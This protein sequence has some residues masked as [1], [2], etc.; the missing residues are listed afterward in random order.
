MSRLIIMCR[1]AHRDGSGHLDSDGVKQSH[2]LGRRLAGLMRDKNTECACIVTSSLD[3][4]KETADVLKGHLSVP[5]LVDGHLDEYYPEDSQ[6]FLR[7]LMAVWNALEMSTS[8]QSVVIVTHSCV[9]H[10]CARL[11]GKIPFKSAFQK[12]PLASMRLYAFPFGDGF[13]NAELDRGMWYC[14][15]ERNF[16][17][18]SGWISKKVSM[19]DKMWTNPPVPRVGPA[20][21]YLDSDDWLIQRD[22]WAMEKWNVSSDIV[23]AISKIKIGG[24]FLRCLRDLLP[25]HASPLR[26]LDEMYSDS[27]WVKYIMYPPFVWR[28]HVHIQGR[29]APL[30]FKNVYLLKDVIRSLEL[31]KGSQDYL[32]WMHSNS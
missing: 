27:K 26:E 29:D 7:I 30:P 3:R 4:A 6:G 16:R 25:E 9:L 23:M 14:E 19:V 24:V 31:S 22:I 20:V 13:S 17:Q 1:H 2:S 12:A 8:S 32:I 18:K 21:V 28:L 11:F 5:C 10:R 15:T